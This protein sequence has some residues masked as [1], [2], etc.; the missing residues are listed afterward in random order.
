MKNLSRFLPWFVCGLVA[1]IF[2]VQM[3]PSSESPNGM[4]LQAFGSITMLDTNGRYKPVDTYARLRLFQLA[5]RQTVTV[6]D[7][8]ESATPWLLDVL[9]TGLAGYYNLVPIESPELV[10]ELGLEPRR[11]RFFGLKEELIPK[12]QQIARLAEAARAKA[13]DKQTALDVDVL[14]LEEQIKERGGRAIDMTRGLRARDINPDKVP[15]FRIEND[16]VLALL[17]LQPKEG[18]RYSWN[19]IEGKRDF[20]P[21]FA[22]KA[23]Q[24][25]QRDEKARDVVD[26]K[27]MELFG[28]LNMYLDL[29]QL[30][31]PTIVPNEKADEEWQ[32][33]GQA[34]VEMETTG[35]D[36]PKARALANILYA[37][38]ADKPDLFNK[39]VAAYRESLAKE[40]PRETSTTGLEMFFNHFEP[41]YISCI[42]YVLVFVLSCLAW[43]G[44]RDALTRSAFYACLVIV[45][46][47]TWALAARMYIQGRP[48]VT[49]LYSSAIFIGWGCVLLCLFLEYIYRNGVGNIVASVLG[50]LTL[51]FAMHLGE[52]GDT[53]EMLQAVLDTNFWL[54]THVVCVTLGYTATLVAGVLAM[55]YIFLGVL[56]PALTREAGKTLGHMVYG[57]VCFATLLSFVGTVLGGIWADQSW[58]RFWGWDPKENGALMIVIWNAL[59]LHARWGGM[60]KERGLAVLAV[61]GNMITGWSWVGTNQL[62]I[63]LH[64]YGFNKTMSIILLA[65]WFVCG[66]FI[67]MGLLPLRRWVSF[68]VAKAEI[69]PVPR[70]GKPRPPFG[71]T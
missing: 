17:G 57:V 38:G 69:P 68:A 50:A 15:L 25:R 53:M 28:N 56:T 26:V 10:K 1:L 47:H 39:E 7:T 59:I 60:I 20:F 27:V 36:N 4:D 49:N 21:G 22:K 41:F 43:F 54:A 64:A 70:K 45:A 55:V 35:R 67:V 19:E 6:N 62:G 16:Q 13:A 9:S 32:T 29:I 46:V 44:W 52:K 63:G 51:V 37:Y 24:A 65:S 18:L 34:L 3:A 71:Q 14:R 23:A 8:R 12:L 33:L 61:A 11:N 40:L 31:G 5:H 42:L 48:P 66:L 2:V 58:G 30:G